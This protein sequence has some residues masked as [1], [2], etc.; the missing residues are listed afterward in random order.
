VKALEAYG[1]P[2]GVETVS[3][4]CVQPACATAGYAAEKGPAP[5]STTALESVNEPPAAPL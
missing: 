2:A 5:P 4:P 3:A 1:P